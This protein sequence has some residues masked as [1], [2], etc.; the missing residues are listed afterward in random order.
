MVNKLN[1]IKIKPKI[2]I[3]TA[4]PL[5]IHFFLKEHIKKLAQTNDIYLIIN[6][7]NDSYIKLKNLPVTFIQIPI[8]RNINL[9]SDILSLIKLIRLF[10]FFKFD[11]VWG[12]GPK[13][14][15]LST[16]A[17]SVTNIKKRLFIFQG[18]V[19]ASKNF[20]LNFILKTIDSITAALATNILAVGH[21]E[22][23]FLV[24][25][26][27]VN[28]KR[29]SVLGH[30]SICGVEVNRLRHDKLML[31]QKYNIP[32]N[33]IVIL[34]IG[35]IH[36]DKGVLD[37]ANAFKKLNSRYSNL[38]LMVV[39]PDEG[40]VYKLTK[41]LDQNKNFHIYGFSK[42][43]DDFYQLADIFCLP[44][45]REGFPI[46][47]L[48]ASSNFLPVVASDIYGN[49]DAIQDKFNG[50]YF[51]KGSIDDLSQKLEQ[52]IKN[53]KLRKSLG[54]NGRKLVKKFFEK[55]EVIRKYVDYINTLTQ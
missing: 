22:L 33:S 3:V 7:S 25:R 43:T 20:P 21:S 42:N 40:S 26:S 55:K 5:S 11:L 2:C 10:F 44:S 16:I 30:G 34:F 6:F 35:R 47:I 45:Y 29:I 12:V 28:S 53:E 13:A 4:T 37:L 27:I 18:E 9:K 52:L 39:G 19:W 41:T 50:L 48:E 8:K 38:H 14:G 23:S 46:S 49:K 15:F 36:P 24:N 54:I 1:S 32:K 31:R 17:S 51:R